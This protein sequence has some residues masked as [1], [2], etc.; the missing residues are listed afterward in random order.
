MA[1][2]NLYTMVLDSSSIQGNIDLQKK[3][4]HPSQQAEIATF[5]ILRPLRVNMRVNNNLRTQLPYS[6]VPERRFDRVLLADLSRFE[7]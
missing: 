1:L 7:F 5:H 3:K 2:Q 4:S 6:T